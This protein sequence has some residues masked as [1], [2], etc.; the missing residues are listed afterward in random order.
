MGRPLFQQGSTLR[1]VENSVQENFKKIVCDFLRMKTPRPLSLST[2]SADSFIVP[3]MSA[4]VWNSGYELAS[5]GFLSTG[6]FLTP[7][8]R[9][10]ATTL[11]AHHRIVTTA[12]L[13]A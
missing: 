4:C 8:G 6:V 5:D 9:D 2:Q 12:P 1:L 10:A 3:S 11:E 7:A 13:N